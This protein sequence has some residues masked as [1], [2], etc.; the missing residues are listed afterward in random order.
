[1]NLLA[2]NNVNQNYGVEAE[3]KSNVKGLQKEV[4][5]AGY[6]S[7]RHA[8]ICV[9]QFLHFKDVI[10]LTRFLQ[11][12][13]GLRIIL[14]SASISLNTL[15]WSKDLAYTRNLRIIENLGCKDFIYKINSR[16]I[17]LK[18]LL[19][20][21]DISN[22]FQATT[23]YRISNLEKMGKL[24]SYPSLLRDLVLLTVCYTWITNVAYQDINT[25][26][27]K[28]CAGSCQNFRLVT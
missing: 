17:I 11:E 20:V 1:M 22:F 21:H 3:R 5:P 13:I 28:R 23:Y 19:Q 10:V 18:Y 9:C 16:S 4:I 26:T 24:I 25:M 27:M 7:V 12:T 6:D 2:Q 15:K 8:Y 14:I